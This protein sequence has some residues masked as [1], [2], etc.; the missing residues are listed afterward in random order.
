MKKGFQLN[1]AKEFFNVGQAENSSVFLDMGTKFKPLLRTDFSESESG[2]F[3]GM[4]TAVLRFSGHE[5]LVILGP[6]GCR[7]FGP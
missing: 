6:I 7:V 1:A 4:V 2:Q 5:S 3:S